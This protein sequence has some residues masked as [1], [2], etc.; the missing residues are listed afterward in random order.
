MNYK[1]YTFIWKHLIANTNIRATT[2]MK[3]V[4]ID[5]FRSNSYC[6]GSAAAIRLYNNLLMDVKQHPK[7]KSY[8]ESI[9]D[10]KRNTRSLNHSPVSS[11]SISTPV[12]DLY[13]HHMQMIPREQL[14]SN[15]VFLNPT[16][17][18]VR[19]FKS[20]HILNAKVSRY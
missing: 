15:M 1:T 9:L 20:C 6:R 2:S 13:I 11:S 16:F 8:S 12:T 14:F 4:R 19:W 5:T 7:E 10:N 18:S 3:N 17:T